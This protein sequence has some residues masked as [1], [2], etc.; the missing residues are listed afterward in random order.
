MRLHYPPRYTYFIWTP[1]WTHKSSGVRALHLLC[2]A[3]NESGEKAYLFPSEPKFCCNPALNTPIGTNVVNDWEA[4]Q[5]AG[6]DYVVIY[7]DIVRGNP[8]GAEHVVRYLLAPAGKYGGDSEFPKTDK[9]YGYAKDIAEKVLC[10]PPFDPH[11][12]YPPPEGSARA[13]SVYYAHKYHEL[14]GNPLFSMFDDTRKLEGSPRQ[15][16]EMLRTARCCFVYERTEATVLAQMCGCEVVP[17][18]T[19]YWDGA[20]PEEYGGKVAPIFW[21][22]RFEHQLQEFIKDTQQWPS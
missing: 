3:L 1:S 7:P 10:L 17:V 9:V 19:N 21:R 20:P 16:A 2:H 13:G 11:I 14:H 5:N 4:F 8:L 15:V 6:L 12:F 22:T 18:V